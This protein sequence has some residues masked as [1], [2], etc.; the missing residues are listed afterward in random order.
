MDHGD[1]GNGN[2]NFRC[3][4]KMLF[5]WD[6][7]NLCIIFSWWKVN[8]IPL[9]ILSCFFVALIGVV[10]ELLK[11]LSRKYDE[12]IYESCYRQISNDEE[13]NPPAPV[14]RVV[15]LK[16]SQQLIRSFIYAIQAFISF[17]IM[18]IFMTYNGFLMISVVIGAGIGFFFFGKQTVSNSEEEDIG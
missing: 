3:S 4:M 2:N 11:Y 18:L 7:T 1:H 8:G 17:F 13:E 10:Y 6:T 9:L 16:R 15:K 12:K 5:N 14:N